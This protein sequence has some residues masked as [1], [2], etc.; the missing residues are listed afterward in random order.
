MV[1]WSWQG[2]KQFFQC[3]L[4]L[5]WNVRSGHAL[6]LAEDDVA[7]VPLVVWSLM[8]GANLRSL[9]VAVTEL[10]YLG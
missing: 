8:D 6:D 5:R 4:A 1:L 9:F 7:V 10:G 3:R 2:K